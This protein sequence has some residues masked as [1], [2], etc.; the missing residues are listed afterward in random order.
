LDNPEYLRVTAY[1]FNVRTNR[2]QNVGFRVAHSLVPDD[3]ESAKPVADTPAATSSMPAANQTAMPV[4]TSVPGQIFSDC[5]DCPQMIVIRSGSFTMG[6]SVP[7]S[8]DARDLPEHQV[9]IARAFAIGVYDVTRAQYTVFAKKTRRPAAKGCDV[10]DPEMR[11]IT[12]P[13]SDWRDPAFPQTDRDPVVCVSWIDAQA[14]VQWLNTQVGPR[15]STDGV[16]IGPYRLPS[17]AEWEYAARAS[18]STPY[19]WGSVA[20]HNQANYGLEDCPPCGAA[21]EGKDRWY[22]TS[23]V[24]SFAPNAFGLYD[25]SGNVWQWTQ[26]C[27][28]YGYAGAPADGSVWRDGEC[29]LHVLRGGSWLDPS[30]LI[31]VTLRNPWAPDSRNN[32]NGF[33]VARSLE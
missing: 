18:S 13:S 25:M 10:L 19:P 9:T 8:G 15:Q 2:R 27:M 4:S 26:D 32:A 7:Q 23:P 20:S 6:S 5:R 30:V 24:G 1:G 17:E 33:R 29:K 31:T 11:W 16:E 12:D 3:S 28:H 21:K 14:Y 22:F